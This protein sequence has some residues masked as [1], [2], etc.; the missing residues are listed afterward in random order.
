MVP[1]HFDRLRLENANKYKLQLAYRTVQCCPW[2]DG[3]NTA[4]STTGRENGPSGR[5]YVIIVQPFTS[6]HRSRMN[7]LLLGLA[8]LRL[9]ERLKSIQFNF[10]QIKELLNRGQGRLITEEYTPCLLASLAFGCMWELM[11]IV[12]RKWNVGQQTECL[13]WIG[14]LWWVIAPEW[15][16]TSAAASGSP[17]MT[18]IGVGTLRVKKLPLMSSLSLSFGLR[19]GKGKNRSHW[20]WGKRG[21]L[22]VIG[23][24]V[25][26]WHNAAIL[27]NAEPWPRTGKLIFYATGTVRLCSKQISAAGFVIQWT[28]ASWKVLCGMR[29]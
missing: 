15:S 6:I 18:C 28:P 17:Y 9:T 4:G 25:R 20:H 12:R 13:R 24:F 2:W 1:Y 16:T 27:G 21:V 29:W 11:W 14:R 23:R 7:P 26:K 8:L 22:L 5:G 19:F 10:N 3:W